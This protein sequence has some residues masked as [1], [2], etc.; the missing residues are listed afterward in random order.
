MAVFKKIK[1]YDFSSGGLDCEPIGGS[2][3]RAHERYCGVNLKD[4][5]YLISEEDIAQIR[6]TVEK[7]DDKLDNHTHIGNN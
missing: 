7:I 5:H 2:A 4:V 3:D 6:E 1:N